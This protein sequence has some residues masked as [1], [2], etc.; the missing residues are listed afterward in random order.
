MLHPKATDRT[1][2]PIAN[3]LDKM[4]FVESSLES[5]A[6]EI[7]PSPSLCSPHMPT[8]STITPSANVMEQGPYDDSQLQEHTPGIQVVVTN[9]SDGRVGRGGQYDSWRIGT[10][11][12]V[13]SHI[14]RGVG[15]VGFT[16]DAERRR[17]QLQLGCSIE[18]K[19]T[20]SE[21]QA[22]LQE[23]DSSLRALQLPDLL[24]IESNASMEAVEGSFVGCD[25]RAVSNGDHLGP[26][27]STNV[28]A[29]PAKPKCINLTN[30]QYRWPVSQYA[31]PLVFYMY[32]LSAMHNLSAEEMSC[33]S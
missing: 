31:I 6:Q 22:A 15:G 11:R 20:S 12:F 17:L 4:G 16:T 9:A 27:G 32:L 7:T 25:A 28:E 23:D 26:P 30:E 8:T 18:C 14:I 29:L 24:H 13:P 1:R 5:N 21:T 10:E 33:M 19:P 2:S 3:D